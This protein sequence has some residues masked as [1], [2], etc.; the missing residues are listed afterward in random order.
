MSGVEINANA[1][2]TVLR[3][4]PLSSSPA[5]LDLALIAAFG[6]LPP[7]LGLRL[8]LVLTTLIVAGAAVMLAI[9]S[10]I[11]FSL[12]TVIPVAYPL[13]ALGL[14]VVA[15]APVLAERQRVRDAFARFVPDA[16]VDQVLARAGADL[17]LPGVEIQ[18]SVVFTDVRSFTMFAEPLPAPRVLDVLNA[19]MEELSAAILAHGGT[20]VS[21]EGDKT[22]A[23]FGA[24]IEQA[25][26]ADRA[27][28]T[29]REILYERLPRFNS[30]LGA[31]GLGEGFRMG[32]GVNTGAFVSGTIGSERR[33]EYTVIGDTIN[34]ASRLETLTK[35]TSHDALI[36][37][38]T[39]LAL[40]GLDT[41]LVYVDELPVR[42]RREKVKVWSLAS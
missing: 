1:V 23:V 29:A 16:V 22:F 27:V 13:A 4:F 9:G 20:I 25:D 41:S 26:H 15:V 11:A 19:Y 28:A 2:S 18:G 21:Y 7:L 42:G 39:R 35:T 31:Q 10:Q 6:L 17:R 24:P 5:W 36:A 38:A 30:W 32:I 12:G 33:L 37:D 34:T 3:G 8:P 14:S 40:Q